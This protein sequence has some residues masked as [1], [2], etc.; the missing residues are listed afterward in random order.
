VGDEN[1]RLIEEEAAHRR[2]NGQRLVCDQCVWEDALAQFIRAIASDGE[3]HYCGQSSQE[4]DIYCVTFDQLLN[5]IADT[6]YLE[7]NDAN[8]EN[9]PY[10]GAEGGYLCETYTTY[11]LITDEVGLGADD[12]VIAD[13][14]EALPDYAWCS[15]NFWSLDFRSALRAGWEVFVDQVKHHTRYMFDEPQPAKETNGPLGPPG[16]ESIEFP[17]PYDEAFGIEWNRKE[18]V[19]P[20]KILDAV[21]KI[22]TAANLVRCLDEGTV[23]F[24]TRVHC[25]DA[26]PSTAAELGPP[27]QEKANQSNRMSPAGIVMFYGAFDRITAILETFQR[28]RRGATASAISI[29]QFATKRHLTVLDLTALGSIPS[30]WESN[31][32]YRNGIRFLHDFVDELTQ[33]I[34]RDGMEHIDYVPTQIVTEYFRHRF[35]TESG[36][37]L[38][39]IVYPSS[40]KGAGS[41]CVLFFT[42]E[43]CGVE[44]GVIEHKPTLQFLPNRTERLSGRE[45]LKEL[46]GRAKYQE[47]DGAVQ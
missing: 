1:E 44:T 5:R 20:T 8:K 29:G 38:H 30:F 24:R 11:E 31:P 7:F 37:S 25:S 41:A 36:E 2:S 17:E 18:G 33:P 22:V 42:R 27:P 13:I 35:R 26:T 45:L 3:C 28:E 4:G 46:V 15:R 34:S 40:R 10:D 6:L 23:V 47:L 39:G 16:E 9:I 12:T 14:V 43:D 21:G 32:D 19:S